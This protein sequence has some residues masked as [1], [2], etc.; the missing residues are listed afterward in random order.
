MRDR[1]VVVVGQGYVGLPLAVAAAAAGRHVVGVDLDAAHPAHHLGQLDQLLALEAA[2]HGRRRFFADRQQ[3]DRSL[4]DRGQRHF[5][6][7]VIV[8]I[9]HFSSA[10]IV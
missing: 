2:Q 7:V 9:R 10:P 5:L 4:F 1:H 8:Q 6:H 3:H